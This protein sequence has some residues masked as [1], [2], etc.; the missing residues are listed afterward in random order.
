[1]SCELY[2]LVNFLFLNLALPMSG[3]IHKGKMDVSKLSNWQEAPLPPLS[4]INGI[5]MLLG[6]LGRMQHG[7]ARKLRTLGAGSVL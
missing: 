4:V 5:G 3:N 2:K 1:M 7:G 6:V